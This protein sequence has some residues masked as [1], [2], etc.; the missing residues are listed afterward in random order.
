MSN[1]CIEEGCAT[2]SSFN[3]IN[4][5][6]GIYC[7]KH[8]WADMIDVNSKKCMFAG[9]LKSP[10]YNFK[11]Q[12]TYLYCNLHKL[13]GMINIKNKRCI[14]EGCIRLP[15]Y[16][17]LDDKDENNIVRAKY[18]ATHKKENM[19]NV[20]NTLCSF[21]D[22]ITVANYNYINETKPKWCAKHKTEEM[23][24]VRSTMCIFYNCYIQPSYNYRDSTMPLY[25]KEHKLD[26]MI[27]IKSKKCHHSDCEIQPSYNYEKETIPIYCFKHKLDSMINVKD[28][29]CISDFCYKVITNKYEGYCINCFIH[30]FP[31]ENIISKNFKTKEKEVVTFIKEKFKDY[32]IT[33]DKRITDGCSKRRPDI[34]FDLG[35]Q[36][37]I[38]EVDE[39]QHTDYDCSCENKRMMELS[40]DIGHRP[41][42]FIRFNPDEY[43]KNN[44]N[45]PSCWKIGKSGLCSVV[46]SRKKQWNDRLNSLEEQINYW[47]NNVTDKTIEIIQLYYD[48]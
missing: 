10:I 35:Y 36:V 39:N 31:D 8:K 1:I 18:C 44:K 37:I 33:T 14:E 30:L 45:I 38:I 47:I 21:K 43:T 28:K 42:V 23:I 17:Y 12:T 9:C 3:Y 29:K 24:N 16:N 7:S 13:D 41:L 25:C 34:L 11:G 48:S 27:D 32:T 20:K 15:T 2:R 6:K 5:K 4:E 46:K 22:C 19:V 26:N 40:H